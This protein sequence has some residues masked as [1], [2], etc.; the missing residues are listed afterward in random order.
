MLGKRS[1]RATLSFMHLGQGARSRPPRGP[2]FDRPRRL[3]ATASQLVGLPLAPRVGAFLQM[4]DQRYAAGLPNLLDADLSIDRIAHP[5]PASQPASRSQR[6]SARRRPCSPTQAAPTTRA[7]SWWDGRTPIES[8]FRAERWRPT[9]GVALSPWNELELG[10]VAEGRAEHG[11][12]VGADL[13]TS[14]PRH[15]HLANSGTACPSLA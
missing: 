11:N 2:C 3:D 1:P 9:R 12:H 14:A 10:S 15:L 13:S 5:Q 6:S 7:L 8:R 4:D